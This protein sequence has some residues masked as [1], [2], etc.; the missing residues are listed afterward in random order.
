M[1]RRSLFTAA[2]SAVASLSIA[3]S[4][5]AFSGIT[6]GSFEDGPF[7]GGWWDTLPAGSTNIT[8]WTIESG[9]VDL[10][11]SYWPAS[12]GSRS[13]DLSGNGP[14]A[15]SQALATT[16]GNTYTVTFDLSGNPVCGPAVK[17]GTVSAT[18]GSTDALS[19]DTGAAGN[20]LS[21]MK[22]VRQTYSFV[23]TV[24]SSTL[25]FTSTTGT[26]CGPAID[27]VVV[28]ETAPPPPVGGEPATA[29]DCKDGGWIA[30]VDGAGNHFK[31]QG[32]CVSYVATDHRNVAAATRQAGEITRLKGK[33][34]ETGKPVR[35]VSKPADEK[36]TPDRG[37]SPAIRAGHSQ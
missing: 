37:N 1:R 5:F 25:T 4:A 8:G 19:Y 32:D 21:D 22:W 30:L 20:T 11:G 27:N 24:A 12:D 34:A 16:V 6:N 9:T 15:M 17:T 3:A 7:S 29:A 10:T 13:I 35:S 23:A 26:S 33:A 2:L 31:N 36:V 18:G 14:G 28:A